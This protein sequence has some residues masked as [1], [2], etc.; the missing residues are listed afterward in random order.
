MYG[1]ILNQKATPKIPF[2]LYLK[3][4]I[5]CFMLGAFMELFMIH[6]GFYDV[7]TNIEAERLEGQ[8]E[9]LELFYKDIK[10]QIVLMS[11]QKKIAVPQEYKD[12]VEKFNKDIN[13]I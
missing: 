1:V 9:E 12:E 8:K 4:G 7:V 6:S 11:E 10:R 5:P 2:A 13:Q 3:I